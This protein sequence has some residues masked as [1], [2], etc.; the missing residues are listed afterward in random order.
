[1]AEMRFTRD[2]KLALAAA[3]DCAREL[4]HTYISTEHLLLALLKKAPALFPGETAV[5]DIEDRVHAQ[6]GPPT[7][8]PESHFAEKL[9]YTSLAKNALKT[10]HLEASKCGAPATDTGH[11]LAALVSDK[12]R[13]GEILRQSGFQWD[14]ARKTAATADRRDVVLELMQIDDESEIPYY[15][16]IVARIKEAVAAGD[17]HPGDRLPSV[18]ALADHLELAPGTVARAF[19]LLEQD[20]V[21]ETAGP[22]GTTI[23]FPPPG[24]SHS[25]EDRIGELAG[26]LRPV[27]VSAFHLGG[28]AEELFEALRIAVAGVFD[29]PLGFEKN[30]A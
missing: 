6:V 5:E 18:R 10:A 12:G 2:A 11:L 9:A 21:V 1:M 27:V 13:A 14:W 25:S 3:S 29:D 7:R 30:S 4:N 28:T 17:L 22:R 15:E 8:K 20:S 19:A 16:Q 23:A 26:L 24:R